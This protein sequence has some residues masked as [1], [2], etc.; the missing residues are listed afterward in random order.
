MVLQNGLESPSEKPN[1]ID[2]GDLSCGKTYL[3]CVLALNSMTDSSR[4]MDLKEDQDC[5]N[6]WAFLQRMVTRHR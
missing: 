2:L 1:V 6:S 5:S 4:A 3:D